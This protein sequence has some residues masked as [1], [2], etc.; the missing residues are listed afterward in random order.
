MLLGHTPWK[1]VCVPGNACAHACA[2]SE[3]L[4]PQVTEDVPFQK[5]PF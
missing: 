1:P 3:Q 5:G 4:E 2:F